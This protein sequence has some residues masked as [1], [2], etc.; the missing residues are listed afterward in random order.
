MMNEK[1]QTAKPTRV[2]IKDIVLIVLMVSSTLV[3]GLKESITLPIKNTK[4]GMPVPVMHAAT[5]PVY[6]KSLS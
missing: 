2:K 6:I 4:E 5:H 1:N 3:V